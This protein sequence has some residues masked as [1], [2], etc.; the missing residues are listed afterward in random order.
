MR[1]SNWH[2]LLPTPRVVRSAIRSKTL[3]YKNKPLRTALTN[4]KKYANK[5]K[6][7]GIFVKEQSG[8]AQFI[9]PNKFSAL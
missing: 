2:L 3:E 4:G 9:S 6:L 1:I 5:G 8:E 7:M